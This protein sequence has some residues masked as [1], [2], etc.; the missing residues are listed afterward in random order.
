MEASWKVSGIFN[1]DYSS[2]K[3]RHADGYF[4]GDCR[5]SRLRTRS[6]QKYL[7]KEHTL[8]HIGTDVEIYI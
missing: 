4:G 2:A 3:E 7:I 8:N 5:S 1:I 6:F